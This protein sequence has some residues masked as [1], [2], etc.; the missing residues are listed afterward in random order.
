MKLYLVSRTDKVDYDEYDSW[1][2]SANTENE[3]I[4]VVLNDT[5]NC[6]QYYAD[7]M[8]VEEIT[9]TTESKIILGSFNAG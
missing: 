2:V 4:Q 3:A 1:V 7:K 9:N 8:E 6:K 5:Y